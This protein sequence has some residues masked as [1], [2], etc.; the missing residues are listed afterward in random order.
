[1]VA[2]LLRPEYST[3]SQLKYIEIPLAFITCNNTFSQLKYANS[4]PIYIN[5]HINVLA[6]SDPKYV[7]KVNDLETKYRANYLE[8]DFH[9]FFSDDRLIPA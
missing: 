6:L 2:W 1:M 4:N 5:R 3:S 8:N 7:Q 9:F